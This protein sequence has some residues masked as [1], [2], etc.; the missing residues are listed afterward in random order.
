LQGG[1][2]LSAWQA[3][4]DPAVRL[5]CVTDMKLLLLGCMQCADTGE[6]C[7]CWHM[8]TVSITQVLP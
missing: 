6:C 4:A 1:R 8:Q 5:P 2:G 7:C 3:T